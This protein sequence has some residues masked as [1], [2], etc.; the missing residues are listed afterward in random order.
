MLNLSDDKVMRASAVQGISL[1][2]LLMAFFPQALVSHG[3]RVP[4]KNPITTAGQQ[5]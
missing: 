2:L 4:K 1:L 3:A 5:G